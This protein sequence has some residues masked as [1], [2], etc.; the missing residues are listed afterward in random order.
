MSVHVFLAT[1]MVST[2]RC[3]SDGFFLLFGRNFDN[4]AYKSVVDD[5]YSVESAARSDILKLVI[6]RTSLLTLNHL[7]FTIF[8]IG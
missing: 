1:I 2:F 3:N 8:K 5:W 7:F 6:T 4:F